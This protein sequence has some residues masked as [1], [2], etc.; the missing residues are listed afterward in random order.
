MGEVYR[1]H[2]TRLS[3]DVGIK[4]SAAQFSERFHENN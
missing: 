3:H 1:A 2:D 4:I